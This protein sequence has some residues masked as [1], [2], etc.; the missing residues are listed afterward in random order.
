MLDKN[1]NILRR[2]RARKVK[3]L[4][5]FMVTNCAIVGCV[6]KARERERAMK[7]KQSSL[8]SP[9]FIIIFFY[10]QTLFISCASFLFAA[11]K[12]HQQMHEHGWADANLPSP[13]KKNSSKLYKTYRKSTCR[14]SNSAEFDVSCSC[15]KIDRNT[16]FLPFKSGFTGGV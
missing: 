9:L 2:K 12:Q 8:S 1:K 6:E 16:S 11:D 3:D 10:F 14:P 13:L 5:L 7:T 4:F 15:E